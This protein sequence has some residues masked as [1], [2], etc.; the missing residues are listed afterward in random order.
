MDQRLPDSPGSGQ[1]GKNR[2]SLH[3]IRAGSDNVKNMHVAIV[4]EDELYLP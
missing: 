2:G 1:G 3:E 4:P